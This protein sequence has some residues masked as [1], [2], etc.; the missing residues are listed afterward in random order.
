VTP[1]DARKRFA[2]ARVAHLA[3]AD[4]AGRPHIVPLVF[5]VDGDTVYSAVDHKP[6]RSVSLRRFA[7]V[8][9]NPAVSLLVDHYDDAEWSELWWVRGD[10]TARVVERPSEEERRAIALLKERYDAYRTRTP[11]GPV[12]AVDVS[13]WSGW[14]GDGGGSGVSGAGDT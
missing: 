2:D 12:L 8:A 6:K 9:A 11:S 3:T 5:A 14:T 4:A 1:E 7:N 10:G 13:R